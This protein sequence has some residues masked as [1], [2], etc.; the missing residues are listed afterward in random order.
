MP[1]IKTPQNI[2]SAHEASQQAL[3]TIEESLGSVPNLFRLMS[4]SP[5]SLIGFLQISAQLNKGTL[6]PSIKE[7]IA[8][9]V[10]EVNQCEYC[11]AAH[12]FLAKSQLNFSD[13]EICINRRG[14]SLD[15]K[16]A[17]AVEFAVTV[18]K[19]RGHISKADFTTV[20]SAG[21]SD[22]Q[23]IEIITLVAINS[24]TNY[25]NSALQT[26]IDFP[27]VDDFCAA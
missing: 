1:R 18:A 10:A 26:E 8:L 9:A 2:P 11:L 14:T 23:I 17:V 21:F 6:L 20:R 24:L 13:E 15:A 4:N 3:R 5:E 25:L 12:S 16:A 22:A 7:R 19:Q 27:S